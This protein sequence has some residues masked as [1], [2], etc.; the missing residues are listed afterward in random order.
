MTAIKCSSNTLL[1]SITGN[2][3]V[4]IALLSGVSIGET[5]KGTPLLWGDLQPG[6]YKVGFRVLYKHDHSRTWIHSKKSSTDS[7][8]PIRIS[9]W[10]PARFANGIST[11]QYGDYF[12]YETEGN[13]LE[14][15]SN[16]EKYDRNSWLEDLN[17]VSPNGTEIFATLCATAVAAIRNARPASGRFPVVLYAGGLGSRADANVELGE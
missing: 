7:G 8:R 1:N 15:S 6:G 17:E 16:L 13:F 9:I 14:I 5:A 3:L 2:L 11:M 12:H 4:A 10:Y